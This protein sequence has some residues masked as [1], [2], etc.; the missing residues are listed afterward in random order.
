MAPQGLRVVAVATFVPAFALLL[1]HGIVS[2]SPVPAIGLAPLF[3]SSSFCF[4]ILRRRNRRARAV[5]SGSVIDGERQPL[6]HSEVV[7][8]ATLQTDAAAA[9]GDANNEIHAQQEHED[10]SS[11]GIHNE[12]PIPVFFCDVILAGAIM[13]VLVFTWLHST[14]QSGQLAMLA[15][16][17]TI[18][19]LTNL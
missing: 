10:T 13:T 8:D 17:G 5:T 11:D 9:S 7:Y 4:F 18:P 16:Y 19:L 12:F 3:F 14:Q 6:L 15:A 1:A 2:H